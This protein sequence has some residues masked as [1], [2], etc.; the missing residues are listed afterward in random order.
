MKPMSRKYPSQPIVGVGA[1][2]LHEGRVLLARRGNPPLVGEWSIPGGKLELGEKLRAG[3]EREVREETGLVVEANELLDVFDS[4]FPDA[5]G[6]TEYHYVLVDFLC[7]LRSGTAV[8]ASDASELAWAAP[9]E[10]ESYGLR[11]VTIG[12]IRKA[13]ALTAR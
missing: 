10:L 1:V 6:R 4:I 2:I 5:D 7:R 11:P 3:L 9:Q 12:V 13:L 8:A